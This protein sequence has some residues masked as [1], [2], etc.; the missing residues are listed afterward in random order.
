MSILLTGGCGFI[1][2]HCALQ[3]INCGYEIIIIDNLSNSYTDVI[4]NLQTLTTQTIIFYQI[5]INNRDE[6][7]KV[8]QNHAIISVIHLAAYKSVGESTSDPLKY[9]S[10][11]VGGL[12]SL[13]YCMKSYGVKQ[14]IFS[15]SATVYGDP[16]ILPLTEESQVYNVGTCPYATSKCMNEQ[17]LKDISKT[18]D[19][20]V[21]CLRYFNPVGSHSSGML[22]EN[23]K[24]NINNLFPY[25]A[26]IYQG[27]NKEL[28]I[29]GKDY[30]SND[31]TGIRDYIHVVDLAEGHVKALKYFDNDFNFIAFNLGTGFGYTVLEIVKMFAQTFGKEIS[32]VFGSRRL[33]DVNAL[34]TDCQKAK[35]LIDWEAKLT[36]EDMV[37]SY[38]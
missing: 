23:P 28:I 5:D 1:G 15:S 14:L 11:N 16:I 21:I 34:Y 32:Y 7:E 36:L 13:L 25:I 2:S 35:Q 29:Y 33:G 22:K 17:I 30:N 6:L 8:F 27:K 20:K 24:G 12:L 31:G 9:Y 4:D 18:K 3:L 26:S 19:I 38:L 37:K 10:N